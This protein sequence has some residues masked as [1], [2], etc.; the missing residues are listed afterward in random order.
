MTDSVVQSRLDEVAIRTW[1]RLQQLGL[2]SDEPEGLTRVFMGEGMKRATAELKTWMLT[3]GLAVEGDAWGNLFGRTGRRGGLPLLVI[4]SHLDTVRHAGKYDGALGVMVGLAAVEVIGAER[5]RELPF[6]VEVVSF[7]DEEG[8]RFQTTYLGSRA[9]LGL[10]TTA[11]L[12]RT[13]AAGDV[14]AQLIGEGGENPVPRY[15]RGEVLA[16][17]EV[18][19]EQGPALEVEDLALGVVTGIAGQTRAKISFQG[20]AAH[21]GT[22]PMEL[23]RDALTGAAAFVLAVERVGRSVA[24]LVA[25]VGCLEIPHPASNVVPARVDLTLDV[26]H[27]EAEVRRAALAKLETEARGEAKAR[28]L[29]VDWVVVQENE[30]VVC[31][32]HQQDLLSR[33]VAAVQ[34]RAFR[35]CSGAGHDAVV[36]AGVAPIGMIFVRCAGGVSHHPEESV[37]FEDV[38]QAIAALVLA[39]GLMADDVSSGKAP[40]EAGAL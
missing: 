13:N 9:A 21:A 18:H 17:W 34:G 3:D 28:G 37:R 22:C 12:S 33:A 16:Y 30:P 5:W 20:R 29:E 15:R 27:L 25:T 6:D 26:R 8:A 36:L 32:P 11:D 7:S 23:R 19:I 31:D 39:M 40:R 2:I 1:D 35:L 4:G 10:I 14:L 24:G 38:K